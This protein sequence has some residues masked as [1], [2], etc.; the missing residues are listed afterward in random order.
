MD[1][2]IKD[3]PDGRKGGETEAAKQRLLARSIRAQRELKEARV[4]FSKAQGN[5][6]RSLKYIER[7]EGVAYSELGQPAEER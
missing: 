4:E 2:E 3:L 7:A 1:Q 5:A 6:L